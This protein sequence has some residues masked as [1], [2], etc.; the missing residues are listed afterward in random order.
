MLNIKFDVNGFIKEL[1]D[2][3]SETEEP[4]V[5]R[6]LHYYFWSLQQADIDEGLPQALNFAYDGELSRDNL[7]SLLTKIHYLNF[8]MFY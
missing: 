7:I 2:R 6:F 5:V 1:E 8:L 3:Y 4:P